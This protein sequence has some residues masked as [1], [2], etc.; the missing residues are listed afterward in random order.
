M[1]RALVCLMMFSAP[2]MIRADEGR[3][4]LYQQGTI[5]Q[6]GYY[7]LTRDITAATGDGITIQAND[8]TLDLNGHTLTTSGS[9]NYGV[10]VSDGYTRTRIRNG[11][12]VSVLS[13]I[14]SNPTTANA[15]VVEGVRAESGDLTIWFR[16]A[17]QVEI[18]S[19]TIIPSTNAYG[20]SVGTLPNNGSVVARIVGNMISTS[21]TG[22][23][24]SLTNPFGGEVRNNVIRA[25]G[26]ADG[27]SMSQSGTVSPLGDVAIEGNIITGGFNGIS[28]GTNV[29]GNVIRVNV[30]KTCNQIGI[31]L[32]S[33]DN[34]VYQNEI[35]NCTS[36]GINV[37]G[38]RNLIDWNL[39]NSNGTSGTVYGIFF[40]TAGSN[41]YRN[42]IT[43]GNRTGGIGGNTGGNTNGGG[44][45]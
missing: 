4:P 43:R 36:H 34:L 28:S 32:F 33:D 31:N 45:F 23:G 14:F 44:N 8:V 18:R 27:I 11:R 35:T 1:R 13:A 26:S 22:G 38:S 9:M 3:I 5:A 2:A 30:V 12:I 39:S 29:Q 41:V 37:Q 40:A 19:C 10:I 15:G 25:S 42:N 7:I 6:P 24:I 16:N 20:I 17:N 21:G